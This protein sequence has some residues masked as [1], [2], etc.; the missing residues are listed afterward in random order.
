[1]HPGVG[2]L[3]RRYLYLSLTGLALWLFILPLCFGESTP[4]VN[5]SKTTARLIEQSMQVSLAIENPTGNDFQAHISVQLIDPDGVVQST[6]ERDEDLRKGSGKVQLS[7]P[8]PKMKSSDEAA[9][10]WYRL[11]YEIYQSDARSAV[12]QGIISVSQSRP[13]HF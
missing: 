8:L 11:R 4:R 5:E 6:A 3:T 7:L 2:M 12:A 9:V 10:F 13:R 1:M